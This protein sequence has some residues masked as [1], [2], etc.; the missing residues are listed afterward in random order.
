MSLH[1]WISSTG[2]P[3]RTLADVVRAS[4]GLARASWE[5]A[6]ARCRAHGYHTPVPTA[7]EVRAAY[8]EILR[9]LPPEPLRASPAAIVRECEALG[10]SVL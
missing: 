10:L 5:L 6:R 8:K 2:P 1:D 7:A 9:A 4:G 3:G